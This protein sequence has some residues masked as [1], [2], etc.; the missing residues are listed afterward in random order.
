MQNILVPVEEHRG[1]SSV[2]HTARLVAMKFG[3]R[4]EGVPLG[5]DFEA[6]IAAN[7][8]VP[9]AIGDETMQ[10]ELLVQLH[11]LF[12]EYSRADGPVGNGGVNY[13]WNGESLLTDIKMGAYARVFD[14][15][16]VGRP[17]PDAHDPRQ[18]TLEAVLFDSGR[19][20]LVVPP[21][22]P[23]KVGDVIAVAWNA[24]TETART[25]SFAMPFLKR[26]GRVVVIAV[27]SAMSPG[28]SA[29]LLA[30]SL[31]SH[32][33][34]VIL[35][36]VQEPTQAPGRTILAHAVAHGADMLVKGGYT[37][38]RLRQMIFGGAT[39]HIIMEANIPVILAH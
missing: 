25:V 3:S 33:L 21:R 35:D 36:V 32:G 11:R 23:N 34:D 5:P 29:E 30:R 18:P 19:P 12:V 15:T 16:V 38:S 39:R 27:P 17:G 31:Q 4:I 37:Q 26:A 14:L 22:A 20:I 10:R 1:I 8:A 9:V 6:L 2:L 13:S 24:S 28:P 7:F